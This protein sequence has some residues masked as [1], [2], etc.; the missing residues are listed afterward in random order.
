MKTLEKVNRFPLG[1]RT[2]AALLTFGLF[3]QI[4]WVIENMYFNVFL[5]NTI[6]GD[7]SMIAAMVAA[8]AVTATVTTLLMGALSDKLGKRKAFIVIGYLL[9]GVSVGIFAFVSKESI[10]HLAGVAD[11]AYAAALAVVILDCVMTFFGSTANDAAFNAWVT[12]VTVKENRGRVETVLA[13]MPLV[14]MLVVFGG[15]D[16]LTQ[17]GNW[18]LF[19]LIVGGIT[20]L[21]GLLGCFFIR[22]KPQ[23]IRR[24]G[25]YFAD[26]LYGFRPSV[27]K[28]NK[29]LYLSL[30]A[31]CVYCMSQQVYMPYLIIYIQRFLG[32]TDYTFLLA[33]VL[34]LSSVA[35]VLC[36][37]PIDK[38]GK[39]TC[40]AF[41]GPVGIV[42]LGLMALARAPWAVL[43]CG[44][45]MLGGGM[46]ISACCNGLIRDYTPEGK[47]GLFQGIRIVFQ[48][49]IPMVTGPYI[50]AA[51]IRNTGL[52]YEDLGTVKQVPTAEIFW[53]AAGILVAL[54]IPYF[55]LKKEGAGAKCR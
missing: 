51:V 49:L 6:S 25:S 23:P 5:Y 3:G 8:S 26:I 19:F 33:G 36:G 24:E 54:A 44:T 37:K 22:E 30:A 34:I 32:I 4:A 20:S 1:G 55:L 31:L 27:I 14:A 50:G 42:G 21:G 47:A 2:W 46:V 38:R 12:D 52:T 18:K 13:V 11:A 39:L 48:V 10:G 53:A 41:A 29:L 35:S 15:L 45:V 43:V 9:W 17:S 7:T 28:G 16:G 40:L